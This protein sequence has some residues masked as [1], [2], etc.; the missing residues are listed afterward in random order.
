MSVMI[1][2]LLFYYIYDKLFQGGQDWISWP[3]YSQHEYISKRN[4]EILKVGG[5]FSLEVSLNIDVSTFT[6]QLFIDFL[7]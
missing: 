3:L 7:K 5:P 4:I 2:G 1:L 6:V